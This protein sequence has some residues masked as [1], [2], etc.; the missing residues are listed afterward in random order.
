MI[1]KQKIFSVVLLLIGLL[2]L[3][4]SFAISVQSTSRIFFLTFGI[5]FGIFGFVRLIALE[6]ISDDPEKK[7]EYENTAKDERIQHITNKAGMRVFVLSVFLESIAGIVCWFFLNQPLLGKVLELMVAAQLVLYVI[8]YR[9]Y[10]K[11]N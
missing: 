4:I 7:A 6:F 11:K 9:F 5:N 8:L 1:K 3:L 10:E 2:F